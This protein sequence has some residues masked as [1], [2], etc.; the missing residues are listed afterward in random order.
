[1]TTQEYERWLYAR[2][3][4]WPITKVVRVMVC[5]S[6]INAVS[7]RKALSY[8]ARQLD[9]SEAWLRKEWDEA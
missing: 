2:V 7:K 4:A 9:V 5:S 8:I 3:D 6:I 1:M